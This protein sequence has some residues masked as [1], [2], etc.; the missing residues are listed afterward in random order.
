LAAGALA[1]LVFSPLGWASLI[2]WRNYVP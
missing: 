2:V 1:G